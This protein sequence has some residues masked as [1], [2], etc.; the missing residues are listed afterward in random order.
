MRFRETFVP[1]KSNFCRKF[2]FKG[3]VF[4]NFNETFVSRVIS[5]KYLLQRNVCFRE[6]LFQRFISSKG[7]DK[8][9][10][11][12]KLRFNIEMVGLKPNE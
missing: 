10:S 9:Y 11:L 1:K 12:I 5:R 2:C 7:N 6:K 3:H 8:L 4:E